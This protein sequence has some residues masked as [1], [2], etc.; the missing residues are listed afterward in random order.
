MSR[1]GT[2]G[3]IGRG[4][5]RAVGLA[6]ALF[7]A[8]C[9]LPGTG[10]SA[11]DTFDLAAPERTPTRAQRQL[12]VLVPEPIADRAFDTERIVV[13][14]RPNEIAYF[15]G[16]QWSDRLPRLV[17][18]R[19]VAALEA[20]GKFRAAGRPGQGLAIDRQV[21]IEI[22]AF[23]Y[24]SSARRVAVALAVKLM[25]DRTGRVVATELFHAEEPVTSDDA[26][27]AAAAFDAA[28]G[29]V[30]GAIVAFVAARG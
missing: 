19:L 11:V 18:S 2:R 23:D 28:Q 26:R 20:S 22:R 9:S 12:Q 29:R 27:G 3:R 25:D 7:A 6:A 17:Q 21:V 4:A 1:D 8:G 30:L 10:P 16:A 5:G 14:P 15:A 13:R 24:E